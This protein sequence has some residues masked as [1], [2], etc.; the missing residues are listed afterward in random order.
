MCSV[1]LSALVAGR[2][3]PLRRPGGVCSE[4]SLLAAEG[5]LLQEAG[6]VA[7]GQMASENEPY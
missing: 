3:L 5:P 7:C 2:Q 1:Q 4:G 6:Q